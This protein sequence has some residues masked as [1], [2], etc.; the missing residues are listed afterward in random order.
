MP[1]VLSN[2]SKDGQMDAR[3]STETMIPTGGTDPPRISASL[4]AAVVQAAYILDVA[5]RG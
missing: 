1:F 5:G 3:K 4:R 2:R